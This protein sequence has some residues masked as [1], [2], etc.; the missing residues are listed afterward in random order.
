LELDD[1]ERRG[2]I[3]MLLTPSLAALGEHGGVDGDLGLGDCGLDAR[4]ELAFW[5]ALLLPGTRNNGTVGSPRR[6]CCKPVLSAVCV[7][8]SATHLMN[9]SSTLTFSM[10]FSAI[11]PYNFNSLLQQLFVIR[12]MPDLINYLLYIT[13]PV[14]QTVL[15]LFECK[16]REV[17]VV[18]YL[19]NKS[20]NNLNRKKIQCNTV[21]LF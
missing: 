17:S 1:V 15:S 5:L 8:R 2:L 13:A 14:L 19:I 4:R 9:S 12:P 10:G 7:E 18:S 11:V 6:I 16:S 3:G 20:S 21:N